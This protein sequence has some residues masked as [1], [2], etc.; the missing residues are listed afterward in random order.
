MRSVLFGWWLH[1]L[2]TN[3]HGLRMQ[4]N[5]AKGYAENVHRLVKIGWYLFAAG[6]CLLVFEWSL[7]ETHWLLPKAFAKLRNSFRLN[8]LLLL[9]NTQQHPAWSGKKIF[10]IKN[11]G[12]FF[13]LIC[14]Y[15]INYLDEREWGMTPCWLLV[16]S[17]LTPCWYLVDTLSV[18]WEIGASLPPYFRKTPTVGRFQ[19]K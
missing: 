17:L 11:A 3:S 4:Q 14:N 1:V 10:G 19:L 8:P 18:G 7:I 13:R 2:P 6:S 12:P 15:R 9:R 5:T 16:N